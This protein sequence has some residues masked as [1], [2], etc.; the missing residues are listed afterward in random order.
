LN[1]R[2]AEAAE[3]QNW[4]DFALNCNYITIEDHQHIDKEYEN[5]IGMLVNMQKNSEKWNI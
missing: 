3:T 2:E 1:E 5:I 4:L